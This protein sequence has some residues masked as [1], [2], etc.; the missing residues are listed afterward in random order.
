MR[1]CLESEPAAIAP[2]EELTLSK[3]LRLVAQFFKILRREI[4]ST[5]LRAALLPN[6]ATLRAGGIPVVAYLI[7][8]QPPNL[9]ASIFVVGATEI[10]L[11]RYRSL[12]TRARWKTTLM[13]TVV[14]IAIE[15]IAWLVL[16][17]KI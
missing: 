11:A 7:L 9:V 17:G 12:R 16:G 1:F 15:I 14:I 13:Q 10:I 5:N 3:S 2:D 8:L 6:T 4:S